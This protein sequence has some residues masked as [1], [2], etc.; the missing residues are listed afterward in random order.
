MGRDVTQTIAKCLCYTH[1]AVINALSPSH[2][3]A[4]NCYNMNANAYTHI[5][6]RSPGFEAEYNTVG[7]KE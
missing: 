3:L 5:W 1:S 2:R 4:I 6:R 7:Y